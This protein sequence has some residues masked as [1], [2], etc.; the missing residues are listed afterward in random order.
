MKEREGRERSN[1]LPVFGASFTLD[2]SMEKEERQVAV[3]LS[4]LYLCER[5]CPFLSFSIPSS[6]PSSVPRDA[7][8]QKSYFRMMDEIVM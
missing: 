6:L 5:T 1:K 3:C 4:S 7:A 8:D 2:F